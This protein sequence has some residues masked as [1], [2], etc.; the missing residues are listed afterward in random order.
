MR[1]QIESN[2]LEM[3]YIVLMS[4]IPLGVDLKPE[5]IERPLRYLNIAGCASSEVS[6]LENPAREEIEEK[7]FLTTLGKSWLFTI[8]IQKYKQIA[9]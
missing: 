6:K 7:K 8:K 3:S 1:S 9:Y 2:A 4:K 5:L